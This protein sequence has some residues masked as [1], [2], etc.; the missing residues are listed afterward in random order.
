MRQNSS[1]LMSKG[2]AELLTPKKFHK[3]SQLVFLGK[4]KV[5][6]VVTSKTYKV[7]YVLLHKYFGHMGVQ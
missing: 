4:S 1:C 6:S 2:I 5:F 3:I 7:W